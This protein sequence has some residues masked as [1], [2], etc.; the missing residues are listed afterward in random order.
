MTGGFQPFPPRVVLSEFRAKREAGLIS[1]FRAKICP[2]CR[3]WMP[4]S[5]LTC[6]DVCYKIAKEGV[7]TWNINLDNLMQGKVRV[8]TADGSTRIGPVTEIKW[9][10]KLLFGRVIQDPVGLVM[11]NDQIE[12]IDWAII[13]KIEKVA[14]WEG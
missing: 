14:P 13:V 9:R 3:K 1:V 10:Q 2:G 7:M 5:Y 4:D 12:F 8:E 6:S 11:D